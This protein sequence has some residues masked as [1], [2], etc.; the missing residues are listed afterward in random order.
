VSWPAM[1]DLLPVRAKAA[2]SRSIAAI[3]S[4]GRSHTRRSN[5]TST[6]HCLRSATTPAVALWLWNLGDL[7]AGCLMWLHAHLSGRMVVSLLIYFSSGYQ[8]P[9]D[10]MVAVLV[11][12]LSNY[13]YNNPLVLHNA[14]REW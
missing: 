6:A 9:K 11:L 12:L 2:R 13:G 4:Y 5:D 7:L 14:C 1:P 3:T 10:T 8:G